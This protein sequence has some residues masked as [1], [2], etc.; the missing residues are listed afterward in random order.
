MSSIMTAPT[1]AKWAIGSHVRWRSM[2]NHAGGQGVI[3]A[4]IITGYLVDSVD[5]SSSTTDN[6]PLSADLAPANGWHKFV[7]CDCG[8]VSTTR[9]RNKM[10]C[11]CDNCRRLKQSADSLKSYYKRRGEARQVSNCA[12]CKHYLA[13]LEVIA[14][15]PVAGGNIYTRRISMIKVP[16]CVDQGKPVLS[17]KARRDYAQANIVIPSGVICAGGCKCKRWR[18]INE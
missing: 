9:S 6:I 10:A 5:G 7:C 18:G 4:Q 8:C 12:T 14:Y 13:E 15:K 1:T 11:R 2:S 17:T 16:F 3:T